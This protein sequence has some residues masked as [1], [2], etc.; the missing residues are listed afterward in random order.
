VPEQPQAVAA[1]EKGGVSLRGLAND[2]G[3][4]FTTAA[5]LLFA[6]VASTPAS[7]E[8][9]SI[10]PGEWKITTKTIMN[11]AVGQTSVR[12]RCFTAEQARDTAT[13]FGP[14]FGTVNSTCAAPAVEA[15]ARTLKWRLECR[16]QLNMD[17]A[18]S[19]DFESDTR[20]RAAI[21]SKA[22]IGGQVVSN[23]TTET[24]GERTGDCAQ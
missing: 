13:T 3:R 18:A 23:T 17:V 10:Q 7:A 21:A 15:T 19:F 2:K 24:E 4:G 16:G 6:A 12:S 14:Q 22:E 5:F 1:E 9:P 11:G 20:Y 8:M